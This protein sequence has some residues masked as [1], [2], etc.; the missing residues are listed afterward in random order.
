MKTV[1]LATL[2]FA[3]FKAAP[4][5]LF[6]LALGFSS[7]RGRLDDFLMAAYLV[8]LSTGLMTAG[9][10]IVTAAGASWR[11]L[12]V[13]RAAVIAGALG[14]FSPIGA[15]LVAVVASPALLPLFRSAAWMAIA[16]H[17]GLPGLA[18]GAL[19]LLIAR[20]APGKSTAA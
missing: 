9:F 13:T 10:L 8:A 3:V 1:I 18:L 20:L 15:L 14:L 4:A 6:S 19:A 17:Y 2:A 11:R 12:S 5:L 7:G 16:L